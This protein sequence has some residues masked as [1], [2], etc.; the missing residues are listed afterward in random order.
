M[1]CNS[2]MHGINSD[3]LSYVNLAEGVFGGIL[4]TYNLLTYIY[5]IVFEV[6]VGFN[7]FF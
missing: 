1:N 5:L 4:S 6:V 7:F 2:L 3:F